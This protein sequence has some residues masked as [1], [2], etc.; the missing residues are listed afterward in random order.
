M[1]LAELIPLVNNL[2]QYSTD[3]VLDNRGLDFSAPN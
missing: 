1:S 2:S 3:L